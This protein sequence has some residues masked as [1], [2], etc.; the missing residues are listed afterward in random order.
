MSVQLAESASVDVLIAEDDA[1]MRESLCRLLE[2]EGYHCAQAG[3]GAA[4]VEM[5]RR[6]SPRCAILDLGM[7]GLDG[8]SVARRLRSDPAMCDLHIHCLTGVRTPHH[9]KKLALPASRPT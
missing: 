2:G 6:T 3:D 4:A 1:T 7:P 5:A 9:G 8:F